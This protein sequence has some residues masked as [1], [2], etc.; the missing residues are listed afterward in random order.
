MLNKSDSLS[1]GTG[2]RFVEIARAK[3][4]LTLHVGKTVEDPDARFYKYHPLSSL[5]V[6]SNIGDVLRATVSKTAPEPKGSDDFAK[7]TLTLSGPNGPKLLENDPA[8]LVL[9]AY[10]RVAREVD[11]PT[12]DFHLVK[13]LP[14]ASGLGGGS[15]NAAAALRI[16][17]SLT[18][19][20]ESQWNDFAL[21]LGADVPVCMS[22]ETAYMSGIGEIIEPMADMGHLH[23]VLVN[24]GVGVSTG[25]I[26]RQFDSTDPLATPKPQKLSGTLLQRA[27]DGHNDLEPVTRKLLPEVEEAL[28]ALRQTSFCKLARMSGSGATC[29]GLY[30]SEAH[31]RA[32]SQRIRKAQRGWWCEYSIFGAEN[33]QPAKGINARITN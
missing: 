32:A 21:A 15:A 8:N 29:F 11:L 27:I 30:A 3:V 16:L 10:E 25:E 28:R 7:A 17:K 22:Q 19:L 12:I 14:V 6:F 2:N 9:K 33:P 18:N 4:N 20:P 31:A 26:F 13:N 5:V 1:P 24:P 23:A